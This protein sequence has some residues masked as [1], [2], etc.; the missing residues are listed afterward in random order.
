MTDRLNTSD[1][2]RSWR[3]L[4]WCCGGSGRFGVATSLFVPVWGSP[5]P[6]SFDLMENFTTCKQRLTAKTMLCGHSSKVTYP[7]TVMFCNAYIILEF[8]L[9]IVR[10]PIL[11]HIAP[12]TVLHTHS[13]HQIHTSRCCSKPCSFSPLPPSQPLPFPPA[14]PTRTLPWAVQSISSTSQTSAP[15]RATPS[16]PAKSSKIP[17]KPSVTIHISTLERR[18]KFK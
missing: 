3:F 1:L 2:R 17:I 14:P 10:T 12:D 18:S 15:R 9:P 11:H 4:V 8:P 16:S 5:D 7:R 13:L 6:S